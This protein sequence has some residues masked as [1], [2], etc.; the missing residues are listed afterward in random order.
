MHVSR[1]YWTEAGQ[2]MFTDIVDD[3]S[4]AL[5]LTEK[6]RSRER[7]GEDVAHVVISTTNTDCTSLRGVADPPADY[8]WKKRRI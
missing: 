8:N 3:L 1:V 4:G 6:L 2:A 7:G 5:S